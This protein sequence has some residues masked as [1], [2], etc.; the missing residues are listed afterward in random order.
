MAD[1]YFKWVF[2]ILEKVK[3]EI[4]FDKYDDDQKRILGFFS[5][6]LINVYVKKNNL[7]VKEMPILINDRK[8][9]LFYVIGFRFSIIIVLFK[10]FTEIMYHIK[11]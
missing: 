8:I 7:K 5:E 2:D 9:P 3:S 6:R 1:E 10:F 11:K 4:D